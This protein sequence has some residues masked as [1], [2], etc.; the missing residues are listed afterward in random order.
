MIRKEIKILFILILVCINNLTA[1]IF[2]SNRGQGNEGKQEIEDI[3]NEEYYLMT[4]RTIY[5]AGEIILFKAYNIS[6]SSV[7][8]IKWSEVLYVELTKNDGSPVQKG[9]YRLGFS[10][11]DGYM[12]IPDKISSGYYYLR[13]Y[14]K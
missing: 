5:A 4:D 6:Q 11:C 3:Y 1:D 9:K 2:G 12:E 8:S 10:G 13:A 7:K 14:T